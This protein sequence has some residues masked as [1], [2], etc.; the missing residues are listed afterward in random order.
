MQLA[1]E[2]NNTSHLKYPILLLA[3]ASGLL[4]TACPSDRNPAA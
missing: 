3:L 2:R 4:L 1:E